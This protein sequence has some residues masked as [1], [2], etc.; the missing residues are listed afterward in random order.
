MRDKWDESC[1]IQG[2]EKETL[3]NFLE[4]LAQG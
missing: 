4:H 3:G 1:A 2:L